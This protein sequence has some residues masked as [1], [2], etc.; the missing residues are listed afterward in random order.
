MEKQH[1]ECGEDCIPML[2]DDTCVRCDL[3]IRQPCGHPLYAIVTTGEGTNYCG[4]CADDSLRENINKG[5][6][7]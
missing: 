6:E 3:E 4:I 1:C 5:I 7:A 2:G